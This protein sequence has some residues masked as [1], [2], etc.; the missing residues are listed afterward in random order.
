MP[1]FKNATTY[2]CILRVSNNPLHNKPWVTNVNTLDFGSLSEYVK[3]NGG[4]LDQSKFDEGGWS[5][6]SSKSQLVLEKISF[7][8]ISLGKYV[9]E[10]IYYGIKT[11]LNEA[12]VISKEL[13][14]EF[15]KK[16]PKVEDLIKPFVI[17]RELKRFKKIIPNQFLILIPKGWTNK[18]KVGHAWKWFESTYPTLAAHFI[19]YEH[20]ASKRTDKGE[21][22]W[23][24]RVCEYY[25][26]FEQSKILYPNICKKP[27][28]TYDQDKFYTN[29]KCFIISKNDKYLLGI[30]NSSIMMFFFRTTIPKL[31]GDFY[32]PGYVFMKNFPVHKIDYANPTEVEQHNRMVS[33]VERMLDLQKREPQTPQEADNIQRQIAAT[34]AAIDKLVYELYG[35]TEEEIKIVEGES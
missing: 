12:F 13:R 32:E 10:R 8:A 30:L 17:G 19:A 31:R 16:D 11:G 9:N 22:W 15:I 34:D 18:H 3:T 1:V 23:E 26:E 24:L 2:P 20:K 5:L 28:F 33:L 27:E 21:Y 7:D 29:Q 4:Q 35:L 6:A 14:N 25:D